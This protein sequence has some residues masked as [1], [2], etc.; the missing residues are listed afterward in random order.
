LIEEDTEETKKE[1]NSV[2][3]KHSF[4]EGVHTYSGFVDVLDPCNSLEGL[5]LV[6][7][8]SPEKLILEVTIHE[9]ENGT[10]CIQVETQK[11]F[12]IKVTAS[13]DAQLSVVKINGEK[14][15]WVLKDAETAEK[16]TDEG[17]NEKNE[18][19]GLVEKT[20]SDETTKVET[21]ISE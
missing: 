21:S 14:H 15:E 5:A 4:A 17:R 3:L 19:Q 6:T 9:S 13:S 2:T 18:V 16:V 12:V 8:A 11:E 10:S 20:L 7:D 1:D